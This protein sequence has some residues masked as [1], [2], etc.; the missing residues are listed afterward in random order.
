MNSIN[1]FIFDLDGTLVD[2]ERLHYRAWEKT[3]VSNGVG[4]LTFQ[5]FLRFVGTSNER[6]AGDYIESHKLMKSVEELVG[7][8]QNIYMG[9]TG[10]VELHS[11]V[12]K[13]L[14]SF[15]RKV[16]MAIASSS[17]SKEVNAILKAHGLLSYFSYIVCGDMVS[18]LK[19]HP[20]I[21]IKT[22]HLLQEDPGN[23][24]VFEDSTHGIHAAKES[25]MLAIA[26]PNEFTR[27]HDFSRSDSVVE[28]LD[29][30]DESLLESLNLHLAE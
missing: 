15:S 5:T 9:L 3:L 4:E 19:P 25:G 8:K 10:E 29:R 18:N 26:I 22:A 13:V 12:K 1:A 14:S 11:G 16:K 30:V 27:K 2:T 24:L 23:C 28:S 7:E 20:E 21:F 17:H 6:V